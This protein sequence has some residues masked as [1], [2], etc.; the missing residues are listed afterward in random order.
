MGGGIVLVMMLVIVVEAVV[1]IYS[2]TS[3]VVLSI[4]LLGIKKTRFVLTI[5]FTPHFRVKIT[6]CFTRIPRIR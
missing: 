4:L 1:Y 2:R 3:R 5:H 6:H